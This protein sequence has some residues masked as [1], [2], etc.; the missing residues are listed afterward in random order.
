M[1][2]HLRLSIDIHECGM[3]DVIYI[4]RQLHLIKVLILRH[5]FVDIF[6]KRIQLSAKKLD[7]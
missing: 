3:C 4:S 6:L 1:V 5:Q 2:F 7:F